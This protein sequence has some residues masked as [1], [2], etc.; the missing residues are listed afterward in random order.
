MK[1]D[2]ENKFEYSYCAPTEEER[3]EI[4][5]IREFYLSDDIKSSKLDR[6]KKLNSY[7][8]NSA[9]AVALTMGITGLLLFGLGMS[10]ILE[11]NLLWGGIIVSAAGCVPM[12]AANPVYNKIVSYNKKKYGKE[13]LRLTDE[14]LSEYNE[15]Q[16]LSDNICIF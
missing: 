10:M 1:N 9:M 3:T 5:N 14:L 4:K 15:K 2:K 7:V 8:K 6:I 16:L 13:I 11:W 12:I